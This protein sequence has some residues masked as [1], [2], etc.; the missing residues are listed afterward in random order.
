MADEKIEVKQL[1]Y[2][3]EDINE[4]YK[5]LYENKFIQAAFNFYIT[6]GF[7]VAEDKY[8]F[9]INTIFTKKS[10]NFLYITNIL[11]TIITNKNKEVDS[12]VSDEKENSNFENYF[13]NI[14]TK[15]IIYTLNMLLCNKLCE[16]DLPNDEKISILAEYTKE[17]ISEILLRTSSIE[18]IKDETLM[19]DLQALYECYI[20]MVNKNKVNKL[21]S[22][23]AVMQAQKDVID[24]KINN[25]LTVLLPLYEAC[26]TALEKPVGILAATEDDGEKVLR[27][28]RFKKLTDEEKALSGVITPG[29]IE[30]VVTKKVNMSNML[31]NMISKSININNWTG[32]RSADVAI[33]AD[34]EIL[35]VPVFQA[36]HIAGYCYNVVNDTLR[37]KKIDIKTLSEDLRKELNYY[38]KLYIESLLSKFFKSEE[39]L[40]NLIKGKENELNIFNNSLSNFVRAYK[41]V[42]VLRQDAESGVL[43]LQY[44][45]KGLS[46]NNTEIAY[47]EKLA[48]AMAAAANLTANNKV[49]TDISVSDINAA[50]AALG[51]NAKIIASHPDLNGHLVDVYTTIIVTDEKKYT[52]FPSFAYKPIMEYV[53]Q[54]RSFD[55]ENVLLGKDL[56]NNDIF[57]NLSAGTCTGIKL[58]ASS[59]SGKGVMTLSVLLALMAG[60]NPVVYADFK[61]DMALLFSNVAK[62]LHT[63]TGKETRFLACEFLREYNTTDKWY[64]HGKWKFDYSVHWKQA[65]TENHIDDFF[66]KWH[67]SETDKDK[68]FQANVFGVLAYC[69]FVEL[70]FYTGE[71][72]SV[73]NKKF[74]YVC[75][76]LDNFY[77]TFKK[78]RAVLA[79]RY[80]EM[81]E[82]VLSLETKKKKQD[83]SAE[84]ETFIKDFV[85]CENFLRRYMG[86]PISEKGTINS[87]VVADFPGK[88]AEV[89]NQK[90]GHSFFIF[91]GQSLSNHL[92]G[93]SLT[94][95][96]SV[97]MNTLLSDQNSVFIQG[98][99][100]NE[101]DLCKEGIGDVKTTDAIPAIKKAK[102]NDYIHKGGDGV[103]GFFMIKTANAPLRLC[104][105]Y[106][107]LNENDYNPDYSISE[108]PLDNYVGGMLKSFQSEAEKRELVNT[109]IYPNKQINE[110]VG[111]APLLIKMANDPTFIDNFNQGF[112]KVKEYLDATPIGRKFNYAR[113]EYY[114]YDFS[115]DAIPIFE[116]DIIPCSAEEAKIE[117]NESLL[118]LNVDAMIE[119]SEDKSLDEIKEIVNKVEKQAEMNN[120]RVEKLEQEHNEITTNIEENKGKIAENE[121]N[122]LEVEDRVEETKA[123][124]KEA[125]QAVEGTAENMGIDS[126]FVEPLSKQDLSDV[127]TIDDGLQEGK[128]QEEA[129]KSTAEAFKNT[130]Q[131]NSEENDAS[132]D[133]ISAADELLNGIEAGT[134]TQAQVAELSDAI[135]KLQEK[136][137]ELEKV[138]QEMRAL[139]TEN[140]NLKRKNEEL[141]TQKEE[142]V[143]KIEKLKQEAEKCK[144]NAEE[145]REKVKEREEK[146]TKMDVEKED[147]DKNEIDTYEGKK[148]E[149][150]ETTRQGFQRGA[151]ND[152]NNAFNGDSFNSKIPITKR[153]FR[154]IQDLLNEIDDENITAKEKVTA[155]LG[156]VDMISDLIFSTMLEKFGGLDQIKKLE[157]DKKGTLIIDDIAFMPEF[158][159]VVIKE[160]P[161]QYQTKL[162]KGNL[163]EFFLFNKLDRF[164]GL[165]E[166]IIE[167][168]A[169]AER[170]IR[171]ETGLGNRSWLAFKKKL[172]LYYLEIGGCEITDEDT[173][174]AYND[175]SY[176]G[177]SLRDKLANIF[178]SRSKD[179]KYDTVYDDYNGNNSIMGRIMGS[180]PVRALATATGWTLGLQTIM[181]AASAFGP[182]GLFFGAVAGVTAVK[183]RHDKKVEKQE[184]NNDY[185]RN[186][187]KVQTAKKKNKIEN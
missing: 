49:N 105:S 91:I 27:C 108:Q 147:S 173:E 65:T 149:N 79:K 47:D 72:Y 122:Q 121:V 155:R 172:R 88:L 11:K 93:A 126:S 164:K 71:S 141:Q 104:K 8:N 95:S 76:E 175:S 57:L 28:F 74:V 75:D 115:P 52:T 80:C 186:T 159:E 18:I 153:Q 38:I 35:C 113:P 183:A 54:G 94:S 178:G 73:K 180:T 98:N 32:L 20:N 142:R 125:Q 129:E 26:L 90:T 66:A 15:V 181:F 9:S 77:A 169:L 63:A 165:E 136:Q 81:K 174:K 137:K 182:L 152:I 166:M 42:I 45:F 59:R 140:E 85:W 84:E 17:N 134:Y 12:A 130:T 120:N 187:T 96:Q 127:P 7:Q 97:W 14:A 1:E 24:D 132:E 10:E 60:G 154:D 133:L 51:K 50:I 146:G 157:I 162:R 117:N 44:I 148:K 69:K 103:R 61:P 156:L 39:L 70:A 2:K 118:F 124:A 171:R 114:I 109:E 106:L 112:D 116:K 99:W 36:M 3:Q 56:E 145:M 144:Q 6:K 30:R 143:A 107:I 139:Q 67:V 150:K 185:T 31:Y 123:N 16:R 78:T 86:V 128:S 83:L 29:A 163:A 100:D 13:L 151:E 82:K 23:E 4:V 92:E 110:L 161:I 53:K 55:L 43:W 138:N 62:K 184:Q 58:F 89:L 176:K 131:Q 48:N 179:K 101:D 119:E 170:R 41:N 160:L 25:I 177:F 158:P 87:S 22:V 33:T 37:L 68:F 64:N 135:K 34:K 168:E 19:A 167:D 5:L 46:K 40:N 102:V 21:S 111:Y